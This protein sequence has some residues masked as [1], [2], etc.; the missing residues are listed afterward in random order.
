[1]SFQL[2]VRSVA[3]L[4]PTLR[5]PMDCGTSGLSLTVSQS[6]PKFMSIELVMPSNHLI[7][8]GLLLLS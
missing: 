1:M 8:C 5:D 4:C 3:K 7:L 6:L 2:C